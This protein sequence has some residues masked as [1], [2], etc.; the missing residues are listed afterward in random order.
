MG[1]PV[2]KRGHRTTLPHSTDAGHLSGRH[3]SI[4][5]NMPSEVAKWLGAALASIP[6]HPIL[7]A[8]VTDERM[9][10]LWGELEE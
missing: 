6:D 1:R 9:S 10:A 4:V 7:L 3:D 8:L 2:D 5:R